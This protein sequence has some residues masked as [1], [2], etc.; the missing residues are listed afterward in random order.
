MEKKN[1][2]S[3]N[4]CYGCGVCTAVCP[5]NI[6]SLRENSEG[7]YQPII[8]E[9]DKCINC[10]LCLKVCGFS[11]ALEIQNSDAIKGYAGW[12]NAPLVRERCSSGGIS[13]EI[14]RKLISDGYEAI[15]CRYNVSTQR[16]EHFIATTVEEFTPSI[17]SKYIPSNTEEALR[18]IDRN[19]K[20]LVTGTP[21]Q[22]HSLRRLIRHFKIEENF[23]LLDFFCHGTPSLLL[24]DKYLQMVEK[25]TGPVQF[26]SWRNK[27]DGGW[28][29]SWAMQADPT[30]TGSQSIDRH[31]SYNI[32]TKEE[33][34]F[35]S[36]RLSKGD[37]FYRFFLGNV[38]LNTCCYKSCQ[39]KMSHSAADIRIGDLWGR[40]YATD[41]KGV[42]AILALTKRGEEVLHTLEQSITLIPESLTIAMEGQMPV[43]PSEPMVRS[44]IL[45]ELAGNMSLPK[46]AA[47][48]YKTYRLLCLPK[49]IINR[50]WLMTTGRPL[51]H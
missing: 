28:H 27:R 40:K 13:F 18:S 4:H 42:S 14:G 43:A 45:K 31:V 17:G 22:I 19:R 3:L 30:P 21:C 47:T 49:R 23:V 24:W 39:Y 12:S 32:H 44:R 16:A 6:I 46:I 48:T 9:Q 15:G 36:S 50:A 7:F 26:V 29:D 37:L 20:Y 33:K 34:H 25:T 35:Y 10:G 5:V 41:T 11:N 8:D 2:T 38:C 1:I 51:F